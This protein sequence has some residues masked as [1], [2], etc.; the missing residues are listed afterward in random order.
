MHFIRSGDISR[1]HFAILKVLTLTN[2]Q[3]C[4]WLL[5][6]TNSARNCSN[7][8][9]HR[10]RSTLFLHLQLFVTSCSAEPL[11]CAP[12]KTL[13]HRALDPSMSH[14]HLYIG[15][16]RVFQR[17]LEHFFSILVHLIYRLGYN[18]KYGKFHNFF[19]FLSKVRHLCNKLYHVFVML[20]NLIGFDIENLSYNWSIITY[21]NSCTNSI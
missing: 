2:L 16:M 12:L 1:L 10:T 17:F 13:R 9:K 18:G 5:F 20:M 15:W 11:Y 8:R 6:C 21:R 19:H 7:P 14:S 3:V 4:C